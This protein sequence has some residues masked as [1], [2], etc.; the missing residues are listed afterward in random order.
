MFSYFCEKYDYKVIK[1]IKFNYPTFSQKLTEG[2]LQKLVIHI[3]RIKFASQQRFFFSKKK[4][5]KMEHHPRMM[6]QDM[7]LVMVGDFPLDLDLTITIKSPTTTTRYYIT[8]RIPNKKVEFDTLKYTGNFMTIL[9]SC[10]Q[11]LFNCRQQL[12][13]IVNDRFK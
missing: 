12:R 4:R 7:M 2:T 1:S 9:I 8:L 13:L 3:C 11:S 10:N 6:S 5:N